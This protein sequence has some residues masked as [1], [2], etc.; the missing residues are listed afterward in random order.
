MPHVIIKLWPGRDDESKNKLAKKISNL[1]TEELGVSDQ[2]ISID[3]IEVPREKWMSEVYNKE[4]SP[5]I[6][7]LVK[8]PGYKDVT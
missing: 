5:K 6:E 4:I 8:K 2:S 7:N 3:F 1:M